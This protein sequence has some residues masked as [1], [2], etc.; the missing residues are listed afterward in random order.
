MER[1]SVYVERG[2]GGGGRSKQKQ[3]QNKI[4]EQQSKSVRRLCR[5][6][7]KKILRTDDK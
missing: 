6:G 3:Q 7:Q 1:K 4:K 2:G 5:F